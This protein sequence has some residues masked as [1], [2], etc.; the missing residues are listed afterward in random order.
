M[1]GYREATKYF[2]RTQQPREVMRRAISRAIAE[3]D[4]EYLA[5]LERFEEAQA[6]IEQYERARK[7]YLRAC[8]ELEAHA[9]EPDVILS[10][11]SELRVALKTQ[12]GG[13]NDGKWKKQVRH[14]KV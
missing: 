4:K 10:I 5:L 8:D 14:H 11:V 9:N 3:L 6:K 13:L 2:E 7:S 12:I 1:D